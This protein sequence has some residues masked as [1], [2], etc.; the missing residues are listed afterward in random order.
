MEPKRNSEARTLTGPVKM[1]AAAL[2]L[3]A[4]F[5]VLVVLLLLDGA[6]ELVGMAL[7]G[8]AAAGWI[9]WRTRRVLREAGESGATA[10]R[11]AG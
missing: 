2:V 4:P 10:E 5:Y 3:G 9:V 1:E 6:A 8:A 11:R 7:Y